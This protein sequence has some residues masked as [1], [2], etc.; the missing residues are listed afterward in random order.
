MTDALTPFTDKDY[1]ILA[2]ETLYQGVFRLSR[3]TLR[4]RT[5]DGNL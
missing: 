5:F 1:T 4:H 3:L 2:R